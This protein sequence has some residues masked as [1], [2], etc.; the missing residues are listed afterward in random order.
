MKRSRLLRSIVGALALYAVAAAPALRAQ[1]AWKMA[2][3]L[4]TAIGEIAP[5]GAVAVT[6]AGR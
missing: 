4:P 2:A 6:S 3:P 1:P 5:A